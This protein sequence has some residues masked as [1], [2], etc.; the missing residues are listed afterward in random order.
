MYEE[1]VD[2]FFFGG[3]GITKIDYFGGSFLYILGVFFL[4]SRYL[5]KY[6]RRLLKFQTL[7]WVS[8]IFL[9]LVDAGF[10]PTYQE[11]MRVPPPRG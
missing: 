11:K 4:R 10:K 5:W 8:Q 1:I 6:F 7:F 3:G 2:I 9:I